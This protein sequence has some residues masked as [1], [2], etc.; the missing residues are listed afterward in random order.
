MCL[1]NSITSITNP[2]LSILISPSL[3]EGAAYLWYLSGSERLRVVA[4]LK[5]LNLIAACVA[6]YEF[7]VTGYAALSNRRQVDS[8]LGLDSSSILQATLP[9]DRGLLY[10]ETHLLI[11]ANTLVLI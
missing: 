9:Q 2:S 8:N 11:G 4:F 6:Y 5:I 10:I 3:S 1:L 7:E